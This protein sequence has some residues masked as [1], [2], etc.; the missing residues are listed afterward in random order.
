MYIR[1]LLSNKNI[2]ITKNVD[3]LNLFIQLIAVNAKLVVKKNEHFLRNQF[4]IKFI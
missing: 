1:E 4:K 3:I 2:F